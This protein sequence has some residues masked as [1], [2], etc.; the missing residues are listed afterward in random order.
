MDDID[1]FETLE[2]SDKKK[3]F[4]LTKHITQ[5]TCRK[6]SK[7]I[8]PFSFISLLKESQRSSKKILRELERRP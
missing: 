7:D 4:H 5:N 8:A 1:G 3:K 6:I 2:P